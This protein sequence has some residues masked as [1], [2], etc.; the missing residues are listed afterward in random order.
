MKGMKEDVYCE[1]VRRAAHDVDWAGYV[2]LL[3]ACTKLLE[4]FPASVEELDA[5]DKQERLSAAL[6]ALMDV[7]TRVVPYAELVQYVP[8]GQVPPYPFVV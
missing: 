3:E 5:V 4:A 7:L 2:L 1:L 6:E 8:K